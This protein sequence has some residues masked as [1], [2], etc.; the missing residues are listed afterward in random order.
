[1]FRK[2]HKTVT[3][4]VSSLIIKVIN[5]NLK[6]HLCWHQLDISLRVSFLPIP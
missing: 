2:E 6:A 5:G 4:V 1:L 3:G